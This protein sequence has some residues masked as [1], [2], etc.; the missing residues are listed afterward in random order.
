MA[1]IKHVVLP[2]NKKR[3]GHVNAP[4]LRIFIFTASNALAL[5]ALH[6]H[7]VT[8]RKRKKATCS[9]GELDNFQQPE[10]SS[11][12]KLVCLHLNSVFVR[13]L[14]FCQEY[15]RYQYDILQATMIG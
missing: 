6:E 11:L 2:L 10:L 5:H 12:V 3:S 15:G 7:H 13:S 14:I 1:H 8:R 4:H 9:N